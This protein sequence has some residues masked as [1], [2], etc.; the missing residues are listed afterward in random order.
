M[1]SVSW[2]GI[3]RSSLELSRMG[4]VIEKPIT[5]PEG[6]NTATALDSC[7]TGQSGPRVFYRAAVRLLN[8]LNTSPNLKSDT[9][10]AQIA[11][12]SLHL[13]AVR[14]SAGKALG[15]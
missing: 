13:Q 5:R 1:V 7:Y 14:Q 3:T 10:A 12:C 6:A 9:T 15:P 11:C 8:L 2:T 4:G